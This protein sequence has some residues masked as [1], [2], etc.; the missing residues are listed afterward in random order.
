MAAINYN[1]SIEQGSYFTI[2]FVYQDENGLNI[3]LANYCAVLQWTDNL[4]NNQIFTNRNK[5]SNY[6]LSCYS[7]GRIVFNLPAQTTNS[8]VFDSAVYD[9]DIQEPNE[10]YAGSGYKTLRLASGSI[11]LIKR[12]NTQTLLANCIDIPFNQN[13]SNGGCPVECLVEDIYS[14]LYNGQSI[15]IQDSI[16]NSNTI[17][18]SD[19]RLIEKIEVVI[20]G[21]NHKNPQDLQF[22][23]DPPNGEKI[24]LSANQ[25]IK[26]YI[27]GFNFIF[28]DDAPT[29]QFLHTI[30]NNQK[31]RI[32]DKTSL[33]KLNSDV[34]LG[35]LGQLSG[36]SAQGQWAL[37]IRDTDPGSDPG[38]IDS[39]GIIV[40]YY[41][42]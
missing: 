12:V 11:S 25:K 6:D 5:N 23:L 26:N 21:L 40:T 42:S 31:C 4:G 15:N 19:S 3:D 9:L 35:S 1:F 41:S 30:K 17:T 8:Y 7:D 20:N 32:Y 13:N 2:T 36:L 37:S 18:V 16:T 10:Q 28:S 33:V 39:W 34:M 14:V 38:H 27:P 24:L 29:N 22:I